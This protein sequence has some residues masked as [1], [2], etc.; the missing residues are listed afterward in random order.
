[1]NDLISVIVPCYKQAQYLPECLNSVLAQTYQNWECIV[2]S[3]GSPDNTEEIAMQY[4][5]KDGRFHFVSKENGGPSAARNLAISHSSGKYILPI[6][7]DDFIAPEYLSLA[8]DA[9][10]QNAEL[11]VVY[12][13]YADFGA[14]SNVYNDNDFD[15]ASF[16]YQNQIFC[17][18]VFR[19][20]D[21]DRIGGYDEAMKD[22][23]E[24]WEFLLRLVTKD[25]DV[26]RIPEVLF[27]YRKKES[28]RNVDMFNNA[29]VLM[30]CCDYIFAKHF[31]LY[32]GC[33][34]PLYVFPPLEEKYTQA[35]GVLSIRE[36]KAY[37]LG[38]FILSPIRFFQSCWQ[39][40]FHR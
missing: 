40:M 5:K 36:S 4:V 22:G 9:F 6:D 18:C 14:N 38:R 24:D 29:T 10:S 7:A 15:Y 8:L 32:Q 19:R 39:K 27:Y 28:S 25:S 16:I 17:S 1:M 3:D 13:G 34:N 26:Y 30:G 12:C 35:L 11:K 2:V 33:H 23:L 37:R 20:S 31:N 21:F